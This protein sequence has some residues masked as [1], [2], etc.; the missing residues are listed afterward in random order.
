MYKKPVIFAFL[1]AVL[2][3]AA[4]VLYYINFVSP[5]FAKLQHMIL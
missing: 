5:I 4:A 1:F 3:I 2:L